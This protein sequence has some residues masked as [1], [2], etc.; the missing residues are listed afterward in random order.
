MIFESLISSRSLVFLG[1]NLRSLGKPR[2]PP[3]HGGSW[4]WPRSD[5]SRLPAP[6]T[7]IASQASCF[8]WVPLGSPRALPGTLMAPCKGAIPIPM[9]PLKGP[10]G[11]M[12]NLCCTG[13][14]LSATSSFFGVLWARWGSIGVPWGSRVSPGFPWA[15]LGFEWGSLRSPA[16]PLKAPWVPLGC[17]PRYFITMARQGTCPAQ[18]QRRRRF[19]L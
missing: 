3:M 16:A 15:P 14:A 9:T 10:N 17:A 18:V 19:P 13:P 4:L 8:P 5:F 7:S 11:F 2:T 12:V 6:Q 1:S